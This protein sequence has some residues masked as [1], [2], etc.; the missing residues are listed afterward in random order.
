[1]F[2]R[3]SSAQSPISRVTA[4]S[5]P[6][7]PTDLFARPVL[8]PTASCAHSRRPY[9]RSISIARAGTSCAS[10]LISPSRSNPGSRRRPS[11]TRC[12]R[13]SALAGAVAD[14][15]AKAAAPGRKHRAARR[16]ERPRVPTAQ[17]APPARVQPEGGRGGGFGGGR[18]VGGRRRRLFWGSR[19]QPA[20]DECN[21]SLTDTITFVD[22]VRVAPGGPMLDFVHGDASRLRRR[23]AAPQCPGAARLVQQWPGCANWRQL[24]ERNDGQFADQYAARQSSFLTATGPSTSGCLPILAI[25]PKSLSSIHGYAARKCA[26]R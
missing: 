15:A 19:R 23:N 17:N 26:S 24:A 22:K 9:G 13:S 16:A 21:F 5:K 10:G 11:S 20:V 25:F 12:A 8:P 1:M 2:I 6:P 18:G 4:G 3:R 14:A 7:S